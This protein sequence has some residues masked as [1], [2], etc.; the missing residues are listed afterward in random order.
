MTVKKFLSSYNIG[1]SAIKKALVVD[2]NTGK[3]YI[4]SEAEIRENDYGKYQTMKV[5]SF[6]ITENNIVIYVR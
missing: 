6:T 5:N 3:N 1:R 4:C 2:T